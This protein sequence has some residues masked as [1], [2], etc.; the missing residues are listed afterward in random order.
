MA[1]E[2]QY[3]YIP[4]DDGGKV[5]DW[6]ALT[7]E[8]KKT[9]TFPNSKL[10]TKIRNIGGNL[11]EQ[12]NFAKLSCGIS[13]PPII[14]MTVSVMMA[15]LPSGAIISISQMMHFMTT[16]R[17]LLRRFIALPVIVSRS[18]FIAKRVMR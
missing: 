9:Y 11:K 18:T 13:I 2:I 7:D 15:K 5:I 6:V 1:Q 12:R 14:S 3:L 8:Q 17:K 16:S 4:V 10:A